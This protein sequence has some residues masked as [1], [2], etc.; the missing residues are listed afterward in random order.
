[1]GCK[2]NLILCHPTLLCLT[3]T[4]LFGTWRTF[5]AHSAYFQESVENDLRW[6]IWEKLVALGHLCLEAVMHCFTRDILPSSL[7]QAGEGEGVGHFGLAKM[8]FVIWRV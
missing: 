5:S 3:V 7:S 8:D 6:L 1:M 2:I 4:G